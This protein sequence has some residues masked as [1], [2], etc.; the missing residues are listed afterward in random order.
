MAVVT[1][2]HKLKKKFRKIQKFFLATIFFKNSF[3][4]CGIASL[5]S[6]TYIFFTK[7]GQAV[8]KKNHF[9]NFSFPL[10]NSQKNEF[11]GLSLG[12]I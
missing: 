11:V 5:V 10:H 3:F 12:E 8:F 6:T 4:L 2:E 9:L 7:I 1:V